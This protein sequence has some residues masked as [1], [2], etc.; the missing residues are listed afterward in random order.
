ML[1]YSII[2]A[3]D[4]HHKEIEQVFARFVPNILDLFA[5]EN[6]QIL[7][8]GKKE[9]L[10]GISILDF[11]VDSEADLKTCKILYLCVLK[12]FLSRG[13]TNGLLLRSE[14]MAQGK[15]CKKI[16]LYYKDHELDL[17]AKGFSQLVSDDASI[18]F[19]KHLR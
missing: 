6:V 10:I 5:K 15:G 8:A 11:S 3:S 1:E 9:Q 2:L 13:I 4:G 17:S 12:D 16:F 14:L 19:F 18:L 7:L